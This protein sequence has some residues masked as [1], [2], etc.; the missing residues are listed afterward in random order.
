[1]A[2]ITYP[3][4]NIEYLAED[5][6]LFHSTRTSGVYDVQEDFPASVNGTDNIVSIG[7]GIGWISN[8]RYAG[9][10]IA[11]KEV[12]RVDM[13][14]ADGAL[15][16]I[17]AIV[18][19]FSANANET[20]IVQKK[21][22]ASSTP[23]APEVVRTESLY[24]LHLYHVYRRAGATSI[25]SS[26]ITDLRA[27]DRY[28]GRMDDAAGTGIDSIDI[29]ESTDD[30]GANKITITLTDG[31]KRVFSV[32][33]GKAGPQG[34]QGEPGPQGPQGPAGS[35][36]SGTATGNPIGLTDTSDN[37]LRGL[38]IYG[39]SRQFSTP[40][41]DS[42]SE[43]SSVGLGG[44]K[45]LIPFPYRESSKIT[46]GVTF[47]VFNDGRISFSGT[48]AASFT[49]SFNSSMLLKAGT[50]TYSYTGQLNS[51]VSLRVYGNS[52][53]FAYLTLTQTQVTFTLTEDT[54]VQVYMLFGTANASVSG[55]LR[56][57]LERGSVATE[58]EPYQKAAEGEVNVELTGKNLLN[59]TDTTKT[60][61]GVTITCVN[62]EYTLN[63]TCTANNNV[64]VAT[65]NLQSGTYTLSANNPK[66]NNAS[67]ALI[68]LYSSSIGKDLTCANNVVNSTKTGD[69]TSGTYVVRIRLSN[70]V[71]YSN[72]T[73]KPQLEKGSQATA[74]MPYVEPQSMTYPTPTGLC[75][76]GDVRDEVDFARGVYVQRVAQL[77]LDG[78]E[79]WTLRTSTSSS[80]QH[81]ALKIG[82][83]DTVIDGLG[84][85]SHYQN[86]RI[87]TSTTNNGFYIVNSSGYHNAYI[88]LRDR[89]KETVEA[90][91][92]YL[93]QQNANG[94]PVVVLYALSTP[95]ETPLSAEEIQAYKA[96]H[97]N[98]PSTTIYNDGNT[99]MDVA[100]L[101]GAVQELGIKEMQDLINAPEMLVGKEYATNEFWL[102]KRVYSA[103]IDGLNEP[104]YLENKHTES[105]V[106]L[107]ANI[108]P[109][110][111]IRQQAWLYGDDIT[112]AD[113][114]LPYNTHD[115]YINVNAYESGGY[116]TK[117][118]LY[119]YNNPLD[120]G[121]SGAVQIWYIKADDNLAML[122]G[123][124]EGGLTNE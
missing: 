22:V 51:D 94:T 53:T 36:L 102:G 45:N 110:T 76:L 59:C 98:Y 69:V 48:T 75:G 29:V 66:H 82:G 55:D 10:V 78:T 118:F 33:N 17:D 61:S 21:G 39:K 43:I 28:C 72:F 97:T 9:K 8:S 14:I 13:G 112:N 40:S 115:G 23:V 77:I 96:L 119:A 117:M 99:E 15:S 19:Q 16:R 81:F 54:E 86:T 44:G 89:S 24:E 100:Y 87:T 6:E 46:N 58:Y 41:P 25:L 37:Y 108:K 121:Y 34:P 116:V 60:A 95:T 1:M 57:Q 47:T 50:Y 49:F 38:T 30:G 20:T 2:L 70:G 111:V 107:P 3:L 124:N 71:S 68:Q 90:F 83:I 113:R 62:G 18:L 56:L 109:K 104:D 65:I 26:D 80:T 12:V 92:D 32:R 67:S 105:Y 103:I 120:L 42:P 31:T 27:D 84:L 63:G 11:N 74:Y 101:T 106:D 122:A 7:A 85:C 52:T 93:S 88:H 79:P 4:N 123:D 73:I 91:K 114:L 35:A 5:A 64:E